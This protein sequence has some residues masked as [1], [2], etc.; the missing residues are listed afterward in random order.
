MKINETKLRLI[1]YERSTTCIYQF[2]E[3]KH[4]KSDLQGCAE[5]ES[6]LSGLVRH[7]QM[8]LSSWMNE[9]RRVWVL[10]VLD[11]AGISNC[12]WWMQSFNSPQIARF[13]LDLASTMLHYAPMWWINQEQGNAF[14]KFWWKLRKKW[15]NKMKKVFR[16]ENYDVLIP[17]LLWLCYIYGLLM[18]YVNHN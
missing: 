4:S 5:V 14:A 12:H 1:T 7:K 10:I 15:E 11:M 17:F 16:S 9:W 6:M 3:L 13:L 18:M 2:H 8:L